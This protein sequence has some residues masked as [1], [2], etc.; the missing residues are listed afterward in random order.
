MC[1]GAGGV[2]HEA[3][4]GVG[5]HGGPR[6]QF[7][8]CAVVVDIRGSGV[9]RAQAHPS[10][11][12]T[13]VVAGVDLDVAGRP[14]AARANTA[15]SLP[16]PR[17]RAFSQPSPMLRARPGRMMFAETHRT[18]PSSRPAGH[19]FPRP[20]GPGFHRGTVD[21]VPPRRVRAAS[22]PHRRDRSRVAHES[23]GAGRR[24]SIGGV[25]LGRG[26]L[27]DGLPVRFMISS[28]EGYPRS[29]PP[30]P[31]RTVGSCP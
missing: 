22:R 1:G 2:Q 21:P 24:V 5:L 16:P 31:R 27:D 19:R 30:L 8:P 4:P 10:R 7:G 11:C 6:H 25:T 23:T 3:V 26:L 17:R 13:D 18:R 28:T 14:A 12:V 20:A 9:D 29:R 15:K